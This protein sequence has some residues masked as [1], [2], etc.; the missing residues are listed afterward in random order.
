MGEFMH[1]LI[2][3]PNVKKDDQA[4]ALAHLLSWLG[5]RPT[6]V[7]NAGPILITEDDYDSDWSGDFE[8][9][10]WGA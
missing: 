6:P 10:P 9:D 8:S 7:I 3:F 5:R 2:G 1:Q 4:D